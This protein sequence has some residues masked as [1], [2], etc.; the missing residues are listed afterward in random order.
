L[1]VCGHL[2]KASEQ[3]FSINTL[4]NV[5]DY[6]YTRMQAIVTEIDSDFSDL[7]GKSVLNKNG[8]ICIGQVDFSINRYR[9]YLFNHSL[10]YK[11]ILTSLFEPECE[12]EEFCKRNF[13]SR[14]S[15]TRH[16]KPL[17]RLLENY[18]VKL[19]FSRLTFTG[20]EYNIR[21]MY[22]NVLWLGSL[23]EFDFGSYETVVAPRLMKD[24]GDSQYTH[25]KVLRLL[26][27]ISQSRIEQ[28]CNLPTFPYDDMVFPETPAPVTEFLAEVIPDVIQRKT[29][30]YYLKFM[31]YY[32]PV[33]IHY[34]DKRCLY[35]DEYYL[36]LLNKKEPIAIL[37]SKIEKLLANNRVIDTDNTEQF[38]LLRANLFS[39]LLGFSLVKG[40][41]PQ[42]SDFTTFYDT[43]WDEHDQQISKSFYQ[44]LKKKSEI[45]QLKWLKNNIEPIATSLTDY[46]VFLRAH[47]VPTKKLVVGVTPIPNYNMLQEICEFLDQLRFVETKIT[48]R[49]DDDV[50]IYISTYET[51][52]PDLS[53][54]RFIAD[55]FEGY[56]YQGELFTTLRNAYSKKIA[57][58]KMD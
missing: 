6:S 26:L 46:L 24:W 25:F 19:H 55:I 45:D 3:S 27:L 29:D 57:E 15:L 53:K 38:L 35:Q 51:L 49:I 13:T 54:E 48:D 23:G 9:Q 14:S 43:P 40:V 10:I 42:S 52:I 37:E 18:Q 44:I 39:L 21:I 16:M 2:M 5:L 32:Y 34:H 56:E 17:T 20:S 22:F 47:Y 30:L 28:G 41:T 33:N 8:T 7:F 12:L 11:L 1:G 50:D 58:S 31:I 36:K 4:A